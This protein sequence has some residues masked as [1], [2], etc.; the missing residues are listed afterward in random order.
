MI[1]N[2]VDNAVRYNRAGGHLVVETGTA[3]G[4]AIL[5]IFNTG[6]EIPADEAQTLLE[7]FVHGQGARVRT[8]GLGLGLSIVRAITL[9]H[10]GRIAVTARTGGGLDITVD[11]PRSPMAVD[12]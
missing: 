3:G 5:R 12:P 11:L 4:H 7:P 6:R 9:A 2:L 8:D 1:G 10:R